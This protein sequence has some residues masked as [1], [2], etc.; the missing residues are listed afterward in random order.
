MTALFIKERANRNLSNNR[1]LY[2]RF[3]LSTF[4]CEVG[5][6]SL[7]KNYI[8]RA[9]SYVLGFAIMTLGIAVS[10]KSNLGVS[11]VSSIPYTITIVWGLEMGLATIVFHIVLVFIQVL[12]LRKNFKLKNL[13]QIPVGVLFG[14]LT[15]AS[16][17]LVATL[18]TPDNLAIQLTMALLSAVLVAFGIFLYVPADF[19]PLAGEGCMLAVSKV[20][21][22][23]FSTVKICFDTAMVL[24]SLTTCLILTHSLGS[25]GIGTVLAAFLVG[26]C[27]KVI[28]KFLGAK[29]DSILAIGISHAEDAETPLAEIMVTDIF[30]VDLHAKFRDV[31]DLLKDKQ[32]SGAPVLDENEALVGFISDGDI[33]RF[34]ANEHSLYM[35]ARSFEQTSFEEKVKNLLDMPISKVALKNVITVDV[36]DELGDV[37]YKLA[38]NHLKKAPVMQ[39][40]KMV[41]VINRTNITGYVTGLA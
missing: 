28:T 22:I 33:L 39:N 6:I 32:I 3:A 2:G 13:L 38:E 20:T 21:G 5:K 37:C 9:I 8:I 16:L 27:L 29:R 24:I 36:Y 31:L 25:V 15:T 30:T 26:I 17:L 34:L 7:K 10:V 23:K 19:I 11:P 40:G 41:G 18:P 35:N 14:F 4:L 1:F 12:L